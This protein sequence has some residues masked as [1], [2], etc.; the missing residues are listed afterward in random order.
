MNAN[1]LIP[2]VEKL[3]NCQTKSELE[4]VKNEYGKEIMDLVWSEYLGD[5]LKRQI[6]AICR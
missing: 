3:E 2:L 4:A 1:I 6:V 5:D